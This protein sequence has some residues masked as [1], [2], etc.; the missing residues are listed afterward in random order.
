M[1]RTLPILLLL[2]PAAASAQEWNAPDARQLVRRAILLRESPTQDTA[3][4]SYRSRAHGFVF[5]LAQFGSG[6]RDPPR[7]AKADE[8]EVEVY[9]EAPNLSKQR[10]CAA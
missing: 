5:Y 8:L 3:L 10:I 2:L 7:L 1:P 4:R 9:W 6:F